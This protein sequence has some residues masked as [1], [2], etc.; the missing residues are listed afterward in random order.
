MNYHQELRLLMQTTTHNNNTNIIVTEYSQYGEKIISVDDY[1]NIIN[2]IG[3]DTNANIEMEHL[4]IKTYKE[5]L[6]VEYDETINLNTVSNIKVLT[7]K[8]FGSHCGEILETL[9]NKPI[10]H[11]KLMSC[12][13][14]N[15]FS[16]KL[17]QFIRENQTLKKITFDNTLMLSELKIFYGIIKAISKNENIE[18]MIFPYIYSIENKRVFK[19]LN[20]TKNL[21]KIEICIHHEDNANLATYITNN[22]KLE[23][24]IMIHMNPNYK[25]SH[26]ENEIL[27][28]IQTNRKITTL[29]LQNF[30]ITDTMA[31]V[32]ATILENN[33]L[34]MLT[35]Y[36]CRHYNET[37]CKKLASEIGKNTSLRCLEVVFNLVNIF[38]EALVDNSTISTLKLHGFTINEQ[39]MDIIASKLENNILESLTINITGCNERM[40]ET[41]MSG[42]EKNTSLKYLEINSDCYLSTMCKILEK[43]QDKPDLKD[44]H[45]NFE[46]TPLDTM[47]NKFIDLLRNNK[48]IISVGD[49]AYSE[50][51]MIR[52]L[53]NENAIE[54]A[55]YKKRIAGKTKRAYF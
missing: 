52:N 8:L 10:E 20:K 48:S 28:A 33:T 22:E 37:I 42:L 16:Q 25:Y 34:E 44:I 54:N 11:L 26:Y 35:M 31:E 4:S 41:L 49:E 15:I 18:E 27:R 12:E 47:I 29:G 51:S 50:N 38:T 2:L 39:N 30:I 43:L 9:I 1:N 32:L 45:I 5:K 17:T 53:V 23:K 14:D 13:I 3:P 36:G 40:C 55:E 21:K 7:L 46:Y 6:I 24:I 19:I